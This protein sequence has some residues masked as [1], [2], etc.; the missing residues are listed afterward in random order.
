MKDQGNSKLLKFCGIILADGVGVSV[1]KQNKESWKEGTC[2]IRLKDDD[3]FQ[4]IYIPFD[5]K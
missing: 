1:I 5:Q 2:G 3:N 4:Y